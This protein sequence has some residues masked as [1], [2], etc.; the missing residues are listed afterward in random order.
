[1]S[2]VPK[3]LIVDD[4]PRMYDSLKVLLG[5]EGYETQARHRRK[6]PLITSQNPL[7]MKNCQKQSEMLLIK[8]R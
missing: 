1:M 7:S 3:I 4:E 5:N 6:G 8:K 2:Y